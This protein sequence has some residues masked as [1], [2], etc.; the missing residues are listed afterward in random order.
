LAQELLLSS[1]VLRNNGQ[2]SSLGRDTSVSGEVPYNWRL[3]SVTPIY[4]KGQKE[5]PGNYRPVS[6]TSV[7]GRIM[8]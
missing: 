5:D 7:L 3:T 2:I 4:K 6:P 1:S 8:E